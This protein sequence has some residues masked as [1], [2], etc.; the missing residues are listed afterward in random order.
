MTPALTYSGMKA[1]ETVSAFFFFDGAAMQ[2][3]RALI[4][5]VRPERVAVFVT[6]DE[7][8]D[9]LRGQNTCAI[10]VQPVS[11]AICGCVRHQPICAPG[12]GKH[13]DGRRRS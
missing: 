11:P 1:I 12:D 9:P 8:D 10:R 6:D 4:F 5:I 2:A 13:C 7:K 3:E